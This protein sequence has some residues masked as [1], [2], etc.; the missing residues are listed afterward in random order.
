[1]KT[2]GRFLWQWALSLVVLI[3]SSWTSQVRYHRDTDLRI[4]NMLFSASEICPPKPWVQESWIHRRKE[5][6]KTRQQKKKLQQTIRIYFFLPVNL[7]KMWY[8]FDTKKPCPRRKP[9]QCYAGLAMSNSTTQGS[10]RASTC[11]STNLLHQWEDESR[12]C[13][14]SALQ[15]LLAF[16]VFQNISHMQNNKAPHF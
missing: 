16:I 13:N 14:H 11:N 4:L 2:A 3:G 15:S 10:A 6:V 12:E 5:R 8:Y 9:T 1:M 7:R